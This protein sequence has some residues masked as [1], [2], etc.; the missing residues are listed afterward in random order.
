[1][2]VDQHQNAYIGDII[3][4]ITKEAAYWKF[5]A[6][7][8]EADVAKLRADLQAMRDQFGTGSADGYISTDPNT[9]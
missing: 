2:S 9:P 6:A 3:G 5:R 7:V 1:M 4:G 8:L